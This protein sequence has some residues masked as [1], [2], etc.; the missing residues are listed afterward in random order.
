[1]IYHQVI[2][3]GGGLAGLRAAVEAS[4]TADTAVLS[5]VYP[6]RSHSGA[7]Q[8]GVN[9]ALA[10]EEACKDDNPDKHAYDTVKGSDF[11][12]DQDAVQ[13][14]TSEALVRIYEMEHWG[15]PFSRTAEGKIAQRPFGGAGYPRT[16]YASDKTGHVMMHTLYEQ[17][18]GRQVKV[19]SE[20]EALAVAVDEGVCR[21]VVAIHIPTG[22][23]ETFGA[24]AVVFATGGIGRIYGNSTNALIATGFGMAI[25]Y[26]AGIPLKDMEF[27]QFHPT[28]LYG[29]NILMTEGAR[30]EGGYLTNNK[31]ERFMKNYAASVMELAPRDI[32][33]R[34]IQTEI[35]QG[36]GFENAYVHL[37]LMH[38]G[39]EKILERL[40]GIRD[41]SMDFA[42]VDPIDKPIPVQPGQ[43]YSM[44]GIDCN[45]DGQTPVKG[46][47]AAGE[48]ACVS[49]HGANRLG[50]NSL[51]ETIVFGKRAGEAAA[52]YVNESKVK[53][54][55]LKALS[56]AHEKVQQNV[57][58]MTERTGGENCAGIRRDLQTLMPDKVGIFR[59]KKAMS[60]ALTQV[61]ELQRRYQHAGLNY[62]GSAF[63]LDLIRA[64][65]LGGQLLVAEA[66]VKGALVREESRGSHSRLDFTKRDDQHWLKHTIAHHT[67]DGARLSH[68][69]VTLT[70]WKPEERKY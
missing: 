65:E 16:C 39:R 5:L 22:K 9:A 40:P 46:F 67:P 24:Q 33:S 30:G 42:G 10:N 15:C 60:E 20:W 32:V 47:F 69:N 64:L 25:A 55:G 21:G 51:L 61:K 70:K 26:E 29:S 13:I 45:A 49:V 27:V 37:D 38:L 41:I 59:E 48:C 31:G 18:V 17:S 28:T 52:R 4:Q 62:T 44:G 53:Q 50:G 58:A 35:A 23:I 12:A 34:S 57:K 6:M 54:D 14:M 66:I 68:R 2:V 56:A 43:H 19:Y 63:N 36:R 8:G 7:A 1:M 3:V 11:L